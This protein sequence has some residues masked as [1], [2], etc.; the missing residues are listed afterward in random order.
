M[1]EKVA[2]SRDTCIDLSSKSLGANVLFATDEWFAVCENLLTQAPPTFDPD[3]FHEWGK[4]MDGWESRRRREPGHDWCVIKLPYT[5]KPMGLELDTAFFTGNY[6]PRISVQGANLEG[7]EGDGW[8]VGGRERVERGG[9]VIGT[10]MTP[11]D[12]ELAGKQCEEIGEW[13]NLLSQ[14]PLRSGVPETRLHLFDVECQKPITHVRV[15]YFPDGGLAR[16]KLFGYVTR[17]S[18]EGVQGELS[19]VVYGG[20]GLGC[21]NQHYGVPSNLLRVHTGVDMGDGWETARQLNRPPIIKRDP[22]TGLVDTPLHDW[23]VLRMGCVVGAVEK[24][25]IDTKWFRGNYPES[26]QIDCVYAPKGLGDGEGVEWKPLLPRRRSGADQLFTY[27]RDDLALKEGQ[28]ITHLKL[29]IFPD[30][31]VSR[32][33]LFGTGQGKIEDDEDDK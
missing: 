18:L 2:F 23:C 27:G 1:A 25:V 24:L 16:M 13:H 26:V 22:E 29:Y 20:R 30:G 19:S 9:G 8:I 11:E 6:V 28:K 31:G 12:V 21:S 32:V 3:A 7:V 17:G 5:S 33:R 14:T 15:N 10:C 4:V